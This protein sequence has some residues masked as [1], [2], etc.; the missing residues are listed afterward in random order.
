MRVS[1]IVPI[2]NPGR[3]QLS[4][5]IDSLL[6][7]TCSEIILIDDGSTDDSGRVC[8]EY[9]QRDSRIK[10]VHKSNGGEASARNV[11]LELCI[12]DFVGFCDSDDEWPKDAVSILVKAAEKQPSVDLVVGAYL[13]KTGDTTRI[14][15]ANKERYTPGE[16]MTEAVLD[17]YAYGSCYIFSTVNGKLFRPEIIREHNIRF[18]D[19]LRVGNDTIFVRDYLAYCTQIQNVFLPTYIYYKWDVSERRQGTSWLYPDWFL[20]YCC[21]REKELEIILRAP[22]RTKAELTAVHQRTIDALIGRLV[23]A[24]AYESC[25]PYPLEKAVSAVIQSD[26]VSQAIP[27]YKPVRISDSILIPQFIL[28]KDLPGLMK[29]LRNQAKTYIKAHGKQENVRF[30]CQTETFS[31][32]VPEEFEQ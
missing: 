14:A 4:R 31:L 17:T 30:I 2:Y 16:A 18:Q 32:T 10:V 25:F 7:Q 1:I 5:C 21:V 29:E 6:R 22:S 19:A 23:M 9:A 27:H 11:G 26:L 12:G 13:E 3:E 20:F 15:V 28:K 8:D 24:A